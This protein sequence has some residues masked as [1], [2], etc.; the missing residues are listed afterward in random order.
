M[1]HELVFLLSILLIIVLVSCRLS[2]YILFIVLQLALVIFWS[3]THWLANSIS[4]V[5]SIFTL[6]DAIALA[7]LSHL[8]HQRSARSSTIILV[9][10]IFSI[11]FDSAQC[12]TFWLAKA[13][14]VAPMYTAVLD[15]KILAFVLDLKE[16]RSI[17]LPPWN[18]LNLEI[19]ASTINRSLFWWLND[20]PIQGFRATLSDFSLYDTDAAFEVYKLAWQNSICPNDMVCP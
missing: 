18:C 15:I 6:V 2:R 3:K 14:A 10:L 19:T 17:L 13:D 5:A 8:E 4:I 16:K 12:R 1:R 7:V 20:L 9:Y 11:A